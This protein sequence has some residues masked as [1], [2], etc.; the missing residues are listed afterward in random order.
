MIA[1]NLQP[2]HTLFVHKRVKTTHWVYAKVDAETRFWKKKFFKADEQRQVQ[3][4]YEKDGQ[5]PQIVLQPKPK[6]SN[7][8]EAYF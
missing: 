1:R 5:C 4:D 7:R 3:A 2:L 8:K 6:V